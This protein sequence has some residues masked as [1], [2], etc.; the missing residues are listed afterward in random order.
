MTDTI[1]AFSILELKHIHRLATEGLHKEQK[2]VF[3]Y[4]QQKVEKVLQKYNDIIATHRR[5][6]HKG[7]ELPPLYA[8]WNK[9]EIR[10]LKKVI[11]YGQLNGHANCGWCAFIEKRIKN[12]V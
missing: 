6:A 11:D 9:T 4:V 2:L 5:Y 7:Q 1:L 10:N 3:Y 12:K 8:A